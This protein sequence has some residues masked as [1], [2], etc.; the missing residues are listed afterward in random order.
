[1]AVLETILLSKNSSIQWLS[2]NP[3]LAA[4][5]IGIETD[6]LLFKVG[7]GNNHWEN[8]AYV[9]SN[10]KNALFISMSEA[11][12]NLI[13][14]T[15]DGSL[16]LHASL[17]NGILDYQAGKE[18]GQAA[19]TPANEY[20]HTVLKIGQDVN[21]LLSSLADLGTRVS[22]QEGKEVGDKISDT[23]SSTITT[24]SSNKIKDHTLASVQALKA[25]ITSNSNGAYDAL[26]RLAQLLEDNSSLAVTFAEELGATVRFSSVQTLTQAQ[27]TTARSN[28]QAIGLADMGATNNLLQ[29]Y[30]DALAS[31]TGSPFESNEL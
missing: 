25:D 4:K 31:S 29:T 11:P 13:K 17:F 8:L 23:T 3:I 16:I 10:Y 24:W 15:P 22:Q 26:V 12:D 9:V 2:L 5:E 20:N 19:L 30:T 21:I 1:M 27:Q 7:D 18:Q 6:T 14:L 28:I